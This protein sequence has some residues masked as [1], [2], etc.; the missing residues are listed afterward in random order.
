[1]KLFSVARYV[2]RSKTDLTGRNYG[3][4]RMP[5]S[6]L[7]DD[8]DGNRPMALRLR[9]LRKGVPVFHQKPA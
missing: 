3:V 4:L 7:K 2:T 9:L 1:M 6:R 5:D 8:K